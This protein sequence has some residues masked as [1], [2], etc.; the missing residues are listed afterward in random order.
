[1]HVPKSFRPNPQPGACPGFNGI[2]DLIPGIWP[3]LSG[4]ELTAFKN[5]ARMLRRKK[6]IDV[7]QS[8][9][10]EQTGSLAN[11]N[12]I[13]DKAGRI[14][15]ESRS[16][17]A[18]LP[19]SEADPSDLFAQTRP[20]PVEDDVTGLDFRAL[21]FARWLG[22]CLPTQEREQDEVRR[23]TSNWAMAEAARGGFVY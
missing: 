1:V 6:I 3:P 10:R 19:R 12:Y 9:M 13:L 2:L 21:W 22:V 5:D 14:L 7:A 20:R 11:V 17:Q 23:L 8:W 4:R 15:Y 18:N 16:A